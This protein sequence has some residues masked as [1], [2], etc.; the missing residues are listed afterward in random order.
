MI[1]DVVPV[2]IA[3]A[4][5]ICPQENYFLSVDIVSLYVSQIRKETICDDLIPVSSSL[6]WASRQHVFMDDGQVWHV[7]FLIEDWWMTQC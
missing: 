7:R 2:L 4:W 1:F 5:N 6:W 3:C